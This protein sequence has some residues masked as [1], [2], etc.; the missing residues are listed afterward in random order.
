MLDFTNLNKQNIIGLMLRYNIIGT[1]L[2]N[3]CVSGAEIGL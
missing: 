1:L 3:A 2:F